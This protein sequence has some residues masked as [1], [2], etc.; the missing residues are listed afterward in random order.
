MHNTPDFELLRLYADH[1]AED[2]FA[3]LVRR[4]CN[5]V[6]AAARRISGDGDAA[7][8]VAQMVFTDLAIKGGRLPAGTVLAG[9][10]Y[11]VACHAAA[12]HVRGESRRI[13]REQQA[14]QQ[15]PLPSATT[16]ADD[17]RI[18][19]ELQPMLDAALHELSEVDRN[20]VVLRF[21]AGRSLAEI[22]AAL[23]TNED[24]AQKRVSRALEKLRA[25]FQRRGMPLGGGTVAVALGVAG[26]QTA[27]VGVAAMVASGALTG[28]GATTGLASWPLLM[29]PKLLLGISVGAVFA[30]IL[31]RQQHHLSH[32]A[33]DNAALR[34]Q[35]ASLAS[36]IAATS[37]DTAEL[38][39]MRSDH[40]ELLR[41]RSEVG[42]LRRRIGGLSATD[43]D[44]VSLKPDGST[45]A[46]STIGAATP[47]AGL[48]RFVLA[49]RSGDAEALQRFAY[50][51]TDDGVPVHAVNQVR[52]ALIKSMT[53]T[54]AGSPNLRIVGE[55][56][57]SDIQVRA[58]IEW[59]DQNGKSGLGELRFA[60]EQGEWKPELSIER[61]PSGSFG[62]T[63]F[64]PLTPELGPIES[65]PVTQEERA[66]LAPAP[67]P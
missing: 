17:A 22:G 7:R 52:E 55:H 56:R 21:L 15:D 51:R 20:A 29:K 25:A 36:P 9:W 1:G 64:L 63:L 46:Y 53:N 41:L 39:R 54:F 16:E 49:A 3:E 18:A 44:S 61:S 19:T 48:E 8:D 10:L 67:H 59:Q 65:Q 31:V 43:R 60:L 58:R 6:W 35:I 12:K 40:A 34:Q 37:N 33:G 27:P 30:T 2:A 62:G 45:E 47:N 14:M 66:S 13:R 28:I 26:A 38:E 24:A 50:F 23:G 57:V 32:L 11:R 42:Q 5:L 4:H